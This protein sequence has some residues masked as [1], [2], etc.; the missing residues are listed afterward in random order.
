MS[1]REPSTSFS[2]KN[3]I[4]IQK[5][6]RPLIILGGRSLA[7][8]SSRIFTCLSNSPF[9]ILESPVAMVA[10]HVSKAPE[11]L[12]SSIDAAVSHSA[13]HWKHFTGLPDRLAMLFFAFLFHVRY[14]KPSGHGSKTI[15][16]ASLVVCL[17]AS[18]SE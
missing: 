9:R 11:S 2:L 10:S 18:S 3:C 17:S 1:I 13:N 16:F 8:V 12:R 15:E 5:I 4:I 14:S 7:A 6:W